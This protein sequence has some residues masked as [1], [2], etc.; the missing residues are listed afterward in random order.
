MG[1]LD[2]CPFVPV[3]NVSMEECVECAKEFGDRLANELGVPGKAKAMYR[4]GCSW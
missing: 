3:K 2:I 4:T 1:A